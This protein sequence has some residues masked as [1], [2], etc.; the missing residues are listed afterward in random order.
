[1][2]DRALTAGISHDGLRS[3]REIK[4]LICYIVNS[5]DEPLSR[6]DLVK[7][8]QRE[9]LANYFET[10]DAIESLVNKDNLSE[11][12]ETGALTVTETGR[13]IA[14]SLYKSLPFT[15]REKAL[16]VGLQII[17]RRR[18]ER[19]NSVDL[20]PNGNGFLVKCSVLDGE[21][22]MMSTSLYVPNEQY[23]NIVKERFLD[24][25]E[26]LYRLV[27]RQLTDVEPIDGIEE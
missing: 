27:L 15:V 13:E 12:A 11:D 26:S 6:A 17:S 3:R 22:V 7:I 2:D 1:M 14:L 5:F 24:D 20:I 16:A 4:I 23:A 18:H 25:P 21:T 19:Q 8:I 10:C 9:N